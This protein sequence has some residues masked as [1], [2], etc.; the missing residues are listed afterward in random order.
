MS[1]VFLI[2]KPRITEKNTLLQE[3][4]KY[5][6]DVDFNANKTEIKKEIKR[7]YNVDVVKVNIINMPEKKKRFGNKFFEKRGTKKAIV[8]LKD[9]QKIELV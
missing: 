9:G 6:F 1:K 3:Q 4:N 5:I 7:L 2:K 8:T